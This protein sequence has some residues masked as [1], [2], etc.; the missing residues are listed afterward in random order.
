MV[1]QS[2]VIS[3]AEKNLL[4]KY[5]IYISILFL[6]ILVSCVST[7]INKDLLIGNWGKN[8][9]TEIFLTQNDFSILVEEDTIS[10]NFNIHRNNIRIHQA[11]T[12][13][14]EWKIIKLDR[15]SLILK[16]ELEIKRFERINLDRANLKSVPTNL[17]K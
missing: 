1:L 7:K 15:D 12:W 16:N 13:Y 5:K 14:S 6:S 10:R 9:K 17:N 8:G 11:I 2:G 3:N 4:M